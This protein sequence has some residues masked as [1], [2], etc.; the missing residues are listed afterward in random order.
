MAP[1]VNTPDPHL[2]AGVTDVIVGVVTT[3]T[4]LFAVDAHPLVLV[5]ETSSIYNLFDGGELKAISINAVLR[6]ATTLKI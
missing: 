2:L 5:T 1:S 4:V 6:G 3:V